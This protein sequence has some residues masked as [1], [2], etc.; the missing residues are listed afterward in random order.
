MKVS[1]NILF[2][3]LLGLL[4]MIEPE[5]TIADDKQNAKNETLPIAPPIITK[6]SVT[7]HGKVISYT[8]TTGYM[9]ITDEEGKLK[10]TMFYTAYTKDNSSLDQRPITYA[11]NGGPGSSSVWLHMG[12]LGPK[13]VLL[14]DKGDALMP[15][16]TMVDNEFSW[17]DFTD[18]VFID[19]VGTGYSRPAKDE[20]KE[21]FHGIDEDIASVGNFIRLYTTQNKRWISPKFLAG[22]SYGTTRAAGLANHLADRHGMYVNGIVLISMVLDFQTLRFSTSN[23]LPNVLFLPTYAATAMYYNKLAADLQ[24]NQEKTLQEIRNWALG[25]YF[26]YLAKGDAADESTHDAI[27]ITLS[28]YTGL[29]KQF[30][31]SCNNRIDIFRFTKELLRTDRKTVGRLDSRFTGIDID[32]AGE[33]FE[34]DPSYNGVIYGPFTAVQHHYMRSDLGFESDLPYEILTGRVQPWNWGSAE[35][36]FPNVGESL[37]SA[38][39]KNHFLK[40]F[41]ANG[42][43]DLATPFFASE[44][45]I[46]H[47]HLDPSLKNNISMKYYKSGHM[48]YIEK[49]SLI[50]FTQDIS[51]YYSSVL[52]KKH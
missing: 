1:I 41:I 39:S 9:K 51:N 37:R 24:V 42:W 4:T 16:G 19:P 13:R 46:N 3:C 35:K 5:A 15:P 26:T 8:A 6:G 25:E 14:S 28:R 29:S 21:Q 31:R 32:A 23:E 18:L 44:Y 47:L 7:I 10:A 20:K 17:L 30:I 11:F 22:E 52:G 36:G 34:Y 48:M 50:T 40:V 38:M 33:N 12:A 2:F 43:Y 27:S 49:E 45:T